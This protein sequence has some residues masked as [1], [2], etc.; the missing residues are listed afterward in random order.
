MANI[1]DIAKNIHPTHTLSTEE[2]QERYIEIYSDIKLDIEFFIEVYESTST[3]L[4]I[5]GQIGSG[6][7]TLLKSF[8]FDEPQIHYFD[9]SD[10]SIANP[11]SSEEVVFTILY[12]ILK[13]TY[14]SSDLSFFESIIDGNNDEYNAFFDI[15]D[16]IVNI[17][18]LKSKKN[19]HFKA[20]IIDGLDRLLE[21][22]SYKTIKSILLEY[23]S[24]WK[25]LEQKLIFVTPL[26]FTQ[27]NSLI[28]E[29]AKVYESNTLDKTH[30]TIPVLDPSD[31]IFWKEFM[32]VRAKVE[33]L[34][35]SD[36]QIN[37]LVEISGG[38]LR[39]TLIVL[40]H[41]LNLMYRSGDIEVKEYHIEQLREDVKRSLDD[42]K[43]KLSESELERLHFIEISKPHTI[44]DNAISLFTRDI[45][46]ALFTKRD[47]AVFCMTHP[48]LDIPPF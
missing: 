42:L 20:I 47:K 4:F 32:R 28:S 9:I 34:E 30:L 38:L 22:S 24:I 40:R 12:E 23:A 17:Q 33:S 16:V 45:P 43:S 29:Y 39:S 46:L 36:K 27:S 44:P 2:L 41:L 14:P 5:S 6:K 31:T 37:D 8:L 19:I 25:A 15:S 21:L 3:P 26:H 1:L 48:L 35:L 18:S 11:N 7:T 13:L 10:L